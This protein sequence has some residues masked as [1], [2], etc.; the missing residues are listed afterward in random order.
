MYLDKSN[1]PG[2][3]LHYL[4]NSAFCVTSERGENDAVTIPT[5]FGCREY[6]NMCKYTM[7]QSRNKCISSS[8]H[9]CLIYKYM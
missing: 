3:L 4:T 8:M 1:I 6:R 9:K 2:C 7:G 5:W